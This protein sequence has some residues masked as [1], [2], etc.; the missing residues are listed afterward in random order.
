MK[1]NGGRRDGAGRRGGEGEEGFE[2]IETVGKE[3]H[4]ETVKAREREVKKCKSDGAKF[5]FDFSVDWKA[6]CYIFVRGERERD[7]EG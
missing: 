7:K 1:V 6:T 5:R 2:W 4:R 3:A